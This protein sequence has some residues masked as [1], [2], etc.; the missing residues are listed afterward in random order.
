M[1]I[2]KGY[3]TWIKNEGLKGV[4]QRSLKFEKQT[5]TI[6]LSE[7]QTLEAWRRWNMSK[8]SDDDM[9]I[10]FDK[11]NV[12][13]RVGHVVISRTNFGM[14]EYPKRRKKIKRWEF[15]FFAKVGVSELCVWDIWHCEKAL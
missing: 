6:S 7:V 8:G 10:I 3:K 13:H 2:T 1:I 9:R 14:Y 5:W 4:N 12:H 11:S 15:F